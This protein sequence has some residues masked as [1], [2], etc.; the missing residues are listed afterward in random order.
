MKYYIA[1]PFHRQENFQRLLGFP[2][3]DSTQWDLIEQLAGSRQAPFNHLKF[4]LANGQVIQNDDTAL[5]ILEVIK[6]IKEGN[7]GDLNGA[8]IR[9]ALFPPIQEEKSLFL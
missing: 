3:P 9:Q 1:T 6:Q 2:L 7:A 5:K 4:R 8:C